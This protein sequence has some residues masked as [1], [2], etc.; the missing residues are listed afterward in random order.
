MKNLWKIETRQVKI[1]MFTINQ[2]R[3]SFSDHAQFRIV[4]LKETFKMLGPGLM[5]MSGHVQPITF[6]FKT[7]SFQLNSINKPIK[8]MLF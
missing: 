1:F 5:W 8:R 6:F 3:D 4:A 7:I 2:K